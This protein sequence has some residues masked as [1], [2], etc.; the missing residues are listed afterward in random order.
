MD[1]FKRRNIK[2]L[3]PLFV[4]L[5]VT[6]SIIEIYL[7]LN[8][9]IREFLFIFFIILGISI[10]LFNY[11]TGVYFILWFIL[12]MPFLRRV[13]LIYQEY[14]LIEI[15]YMVPD[16]LIIFSFSYIFISNIENFKK[17][18]KIPE[19]KILFFLQ[20]VMFLEIFNPLQGSL[21]GG[22][23]GAKFLLLPTLL[24][25][26]VFI[27]RKNHLKSLKKFLFFSGIISIIYAILQLNIKYFP[28]EKIWLTNIKEEYP[29]IFDTFSGNIRPFSFFSSVSEFGQFM[30]ILALVSLFFIKSNI[31]YL[32]LILFI[33]GIVISGVRSA[34]YAFIITSIFIIIFTRTENSKD[35]Y[36]FLFIVFIIWVFLVNILNFSN[37]DT[38]TYTGRF[39]QGVFDPLSKNSSLHP[40]LNT[41]KEIL[42]TTFT[43]KPFGMGLGVATRSSVRFGGYVSIADS[44]FMG[45]FSACGLIGGFLLIYLL[46]SI[47]LKSIKSEREKKR[48]ILFPLSLIISISVGQLLTQYLIGALFWVSLGIWVYNYYNY[49]PDKY[50]DD[51]LK[52]E[53]YDKKIFLKQNQH[54]I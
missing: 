3:Y 21:L 51:H 47:V 11:S 36:K 4:I 46:M 27:D 10:I 41:W 19:F 2:Y 44:T 13:L 25:Y 31:R 53:V 20:I 7:L 23:G 35:F 32:F 14:E 42:I 34:L 40:R 17:V 15:I 48:E 29:S 16:L 8:L 45:M 1:R 18:L 38:R 12:F 37:I 49:K 52:K 28:F 39:L 30:G 33:Y 50:K 43:Q 9:K 6:I 22:F 26:I 5:I 24:S 54:R